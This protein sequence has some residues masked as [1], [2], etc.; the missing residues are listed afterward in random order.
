MDDACA[1]WR[2][3]WA[4]RE[5]SALLDHRHNVEI[6]PADVERLILEHGVSQLRALWSPPT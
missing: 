3:G 2:D 5:I 4:P 6:S 1:L